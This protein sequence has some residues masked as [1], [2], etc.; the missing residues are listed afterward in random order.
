MVNFIPKLLKINKCFLYDL[1][2][3]VYSPAWPTDIPLIVSL[4]SRVSLTEFLHI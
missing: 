1:L 3:K 2:Y 4:P